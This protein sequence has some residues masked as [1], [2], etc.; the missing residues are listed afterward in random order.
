MYVSVTSSRTSVSPDQMRIEA[1][2][3][4][5]KLIIAI[6]GESTWVC[7]LALKQYRKTVATT[8]IV[9]APRQARGRGRQRAFS[10]AAVCVR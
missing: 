1:K 10:A 5:A 4:T 9:Q 6:D 3:P 7:T 8:E 2:G